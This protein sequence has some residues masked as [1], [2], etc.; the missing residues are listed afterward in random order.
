MTKSPQAARVV[1]M[2]ALIRRHLAGEPPEMQGA[3]LADLLSTWLAGHHVAGDADATRNL[4]AELL[5]KHCQTVRE[6]VPI[7]AERI[8]TTP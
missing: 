7:E 6:L 4:R 5:A 2:V 8:G 1:A 3:A